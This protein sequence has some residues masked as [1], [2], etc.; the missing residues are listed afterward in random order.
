MNEYHKEIKEAQ[1]GDKNSFLALFERYQNDIYRLAYINVKNEE[2][3]LD[4]V[5]ETAYRSFKSIKTLKE[6]KYF[7]TWLMKIAI[8]CS[9]DLLRKKNK[10]VPMEPQIINES[11]TSD[12]TLDTNI[13]LSLTLEDLIDELDVSEKNVVLLRFYQDYTF[14]EIS[15]ILEIPIGSAKTILYRAL[16]KMKKSLKEVHSV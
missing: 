9:I 14:K 10:L 8:S 7:K 13:L 4:I 6:P 3:A 16:N 15:N 12:V 5:Q 1:Q 2:E 11:I